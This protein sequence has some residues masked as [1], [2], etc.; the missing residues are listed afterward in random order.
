AAI[1]LTNGT[2]LI[3]GGTSFSGSV[4]NCEIYNPASGTWSLT[5]SLNTNRINHSMTLLPNGKVLA[6]AGGNAATE[7]YDPPSGTWTLTAN[8]LS[9]GRSYTST[10]LLPNGKVLIAGGSG[11]GANPS[12]TNT[13]LFDPTTGLWSNTG[14]LHTGRQYHSATLL[15]NGKVLVAG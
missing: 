10:I 1:L 3:S 5:G 8:T 11:L 4:T 14:P 7:I 2:V 6:V 12:Q 13:A 9:S 15:P